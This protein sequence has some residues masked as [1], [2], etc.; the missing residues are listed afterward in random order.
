[1]S[2]LNKVKLGDIILTD[3]PPR[4]NGVRQHQTLR[5]CSPVSDNARCPAGEEAREVGWC[6]PDQS[7]WDHQPGE[8]LE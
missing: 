8:S 7:V 3:R 5:A 4:N 2:H 1:M 6:C